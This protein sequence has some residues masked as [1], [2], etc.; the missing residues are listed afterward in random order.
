MTERPSWLDWVSEPTERPAPSALRWAAAV[1]VTLFVAPLAA[2]ASWLFAVAGIGDGSVMGL[3]VL[4]YSYLFGGLPALLAVGVL[5]AI[6]A[7]AVRRRRR[8]RTLRLLYVATAVGAA[9]PLLFDLAMAIRDGDLLGWP[10]P[11]LFFAVNGAI[12]GPIA[13]WVF[14]RLL[15]GRWEGNGLAAD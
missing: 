6:S 8:F 14:Q 12:A 9:I 13:A 15:W 1:I 3:V 5:V 11:A 10:G 2:P 4:L 7:R